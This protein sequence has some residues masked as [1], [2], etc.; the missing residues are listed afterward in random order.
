MTEPK[1]NE[2]EFPKHLDALKKEAYAKSFSDTLNCDAS[3]SALCEYFHYYGF[4][5]VALVSTADYRIGSLNYKDLHLVGH[6]WRVENSKATVLLAHGLFDHVGLF[7]KVIRF[8][9]QEGYSVFAVDMPGHGLSEGPIAE[10][11]DFCEYSEVL[12][13]SLEIVMTENAEQEFI[14][15]GQS[16]GGAAVAHYLM[17]GKKQSRISKAVL[18]APLLRPKS[19]WSVNFGWWLAHKFVAQVPRRFAE[20]SNDKYFLDFL[21]NKDPLQPLSISVRWLGAMRQW[22]KS[23]PRFVPCE[24]PVLIV[25]GDADGTVDWKY[26]LPV[27]QKQFPNSKV[28][29]LAGAKHHLANESESYMLE[30]KSTIVEFLSKR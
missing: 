1:A 27:F 7:L 6:W 20:N 8:L 2:T 13:K 12:E 16:T 29:M 9:L 22:V 3:S 14:M 5:D 30:L 4:A 18:L 11:E 28:V 10:I 15:L 26:N 23:F 21:A 17:T 19:W 25:Q 24:S